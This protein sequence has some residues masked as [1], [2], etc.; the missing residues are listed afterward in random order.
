MI[1][2]FIATDTCLLIQNVLKIIYY[3]RTIPNFTT[4]YQYLIHNNKTLFYKK[5][6]LY[7]LNKMKITFDNHC[8]IDIKQ[9]RPT[10]NY[11]KFHAIIH[12]VKCIQDYG[13]AI[14]YD[15]IYDETTH[16]FIFK[17]SIELLI[18]KSMRCGFYIK[19]YVISI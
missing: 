10:I 8:S 2:Q 6:T 15:K 5:H 13:S 4:S 1:K 3:S 12:F 19:M 18:K 9:F 7:K 16:K 14:N 17:T 11:P